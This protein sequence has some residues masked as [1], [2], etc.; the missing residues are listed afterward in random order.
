[1]TLLP[2]SNQQNPEDTLTKR[3]RDLWG[4][5]QD[6]LK[7]NQRL[8][9][10]MRELEQNPHQENDLLT[11]LEKA[12][13]DLQ[14]AQK[15]VIELQKELR[16]LRNNNSELIPSNQPKQQTKII[17]NI[18]IAQ[19]HDTSINAYEQLAQTPPSTSSHQSRAVQEQ[20]RILAP[21][22]T[23]QP[24]IPIPMN[25]QRLS[26]L[27]NMGREEDLLKL[28]VTKVGVDENT[29]RQSKTDQSI[30]LKPNQSS[31]YHYLV[32]PGDKDAFIAVPK[33]GMVIQAKIASMIA[34]KD[35][36]EVSG[37]SGRIRSI[38]APALLTKQGDNFRILQKGHLTLG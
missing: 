13:A 18:T 5:C 22:V 19:G 34:L 2:D 30:T 27:Y 23:T 11:R 3:F 6:I 4:S 12:E 21:A 17:H 33:M 16:E 8:K 20:T 24:S 9:Q 35:L 32:L 26:P 1:M 7:E 15:R 37:E 36:Y 38:E 31:Q 14:A 10:R 25:W 28:S 29:Q